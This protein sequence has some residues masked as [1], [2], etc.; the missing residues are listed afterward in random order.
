MA[1]TR[2][3]LRRR[4]TDV[5]VRARDPV[6]SALFGRP[7]GVSTARRRLSRNA[8]SYSDAIPDSI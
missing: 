2:L 5:H 4:Y 7:R 1:V 6:L 3:V 8:P